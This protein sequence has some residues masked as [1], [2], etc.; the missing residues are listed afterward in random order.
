[1]PARVS[2]HPLSMLRLPQG[3]LYKWIFALEATGTGVW[4]LA[5]PKQAHQIVLQLADPPAAGGHHDVRHRP[6]DVCLGLPRQAEAPA[7]GA[8]HLPPVK[9]VRIEVPPRRFIGG[10][11]GG[12]VGKASDLARVFTKAPGTQ[13]GPGQIRHRIADARAFPV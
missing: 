10:N 9:A 5:A 8:E 13:T 7:Q 2:G 6:V 12:A 4:E 3:S 1:M 11:H